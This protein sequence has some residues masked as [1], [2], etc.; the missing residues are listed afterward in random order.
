MSE[1]YGAERV[2][3]TKRI[4]ISFTGTGMEFF[5]I[6]IVNVGL[7]IVTLGIYSAWAKV[8]TKRYF[9]GNTIVEGTAFS[10]DAN[11]ISILKGRIL[12][13]VIFG[14]YS[15]ILRVMPAFGPKVAIAVTALVFII[16]VLV[17][18]WFIMKSVKFNMRYSSYRNI[19]FGFDGTYLEVLLY[20][21][22]MYIV[23]VFTLG[24]FFPYASF[25]QKKYLIEKSRY[26]KTNFENNATGG[27]FYICYIGA[28][29]VVSVIALIVGMVFF[30]LL[31]L[32]GGFSFDEKSI[33]MLFI[34]YPVFILIMVAVNVGV[35]VLIFNHML[36]HTSIGEKKIFSEMKAMDMVKIYVVNIFAVLFSLGMLIPWALVRVYKY[37]IEHV[38]LSESGDMDSFEAAENEDITALGDEVGEIFD[39]DISF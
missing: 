38:S 31:N 30:I 15:V 7:S 8:R 34:L 36:G 20:W 1:Q 13:V 11:P 2:E 18:P 29:F 23:G 5:K 4:P 10:Y 28:Y 24:L 22:V 17:I 9:Y 19:R 12:A 27:Y 21:I 33:R 35:R 6:W 37:R 3:G 39:L 16:Y 32:F 14:L 26:G 25:L